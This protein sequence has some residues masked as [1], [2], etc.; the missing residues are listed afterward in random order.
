LIDGQGGGERMW[1]QIVVSIF[2]FCRPA[3]L[4]GDGRRENEIK[5][6]NQT[7]WAPVV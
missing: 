6:Q 4:N 5:K 1:R 3:I 2:F 7:D